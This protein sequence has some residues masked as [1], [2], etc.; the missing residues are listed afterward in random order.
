MRATEYGVQIPPFVLLVLSM[1]GA[2][3]AVGVSGDAVPSDLDSRPRLVS[4]ASLARSPEELANA[5]H[6]SRAS[7]NRWW[8]PVRM[9]SDD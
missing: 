1:G 7:A 6:A 8:A 2:G 3:C 9:E 5:A 4:H